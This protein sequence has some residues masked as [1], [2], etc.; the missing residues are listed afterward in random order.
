MET[1]IKDKMVKASPRAKAKGAVKVVKKSTAK[2]STKKV[3]PEV[4]ITESGP[5]TV[6]EDDFV[7]EPTVEDK[8]EIKVIEQ[9]FVQ[10]NED[11]FS[12]LKRGQIE[13][14]KRTVAKDATDDELQMFLQ[15]C[16]GAK[17]NPFLK[18][19]HFV[20][21]GGNASII[22]G[23]DGF[24]S[25]AERTGAYAGSDDA[26]IEEKDGKPVKASVTVY[27]IVQGERYSFTATARFSEYSTGK[28]KW[29]SMPFTMI[30]KCAEAL[31]LRKAFPQQLSGFYTPE[32]M[33]QAETQGESVEQKFIRVKGMLDKLKDV[34]GLEQAKKN[35]AGSK[36]YDDEQKKELAKHINNR[37]KE[38]G[39]KVEPTDAEQRNAEA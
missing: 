17:L 35:I 33:E 36:L 30:A 5:T 15:V 26:V 32:E 27:K 19:V 22:V 2:K 29:A 16:K 1:N 10:A 3:K 23:I 6:I 21:F 25:T 18:Q 11:P 8:K 4:K 20:K 7:T 38:M 13:L 37:I 24:R 31:A 39:K 28:Q 34:K 12:T 9:H 14:I